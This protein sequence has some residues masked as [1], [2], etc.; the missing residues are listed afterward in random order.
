MSCHITRCTDIS[1]HR[2]TPDQSLAHP[3]RPINLQ[4]KPITTEGSVHRR[5]NGSQPSAAPVYHASIHTVAKPQSLSLLSL[6]TPSLS[7]D[8]PFPTVSSL[9]TTT[10]RLIASYQ[11][12]PRLVLAFSPPH[13]VGKRPQSSSA[14]EASNQWFSHVS[15]Q[16]SSRQSSSESSPSDLPEST[17]RWP[18]ISLENLTAANSNR[19]WATCATKGNFIIFWEIQGYFSLL[20]IQ[21]HSGNFLRFLT[22]FILFLY[23]SI[24]KFSCML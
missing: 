22:V 5:S 10:K 18:E 4:I 3:D 21:W 9:Q 15:H 23:I 14:T 12:N 24:C 8:L 13:P 6:V 11:V 16:R 1:V 20:P 2:T 7:S 19:A 17:I